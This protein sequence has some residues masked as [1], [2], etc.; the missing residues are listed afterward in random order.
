M[1]KILDIL[2]LFL[3]TVLVINLFA[4][5]SEKQATGNVIFEAT[6]NAYTIPASVGLNIKNDTQAEISLHTCNDVKV[7]YAGT[8]V[9]FNN[10]MVS[11]KDDFCEN[12]SIAPSSTYL[13]DYTNYYREF[14]QA[15]NY[16]FKVQFD[17]KEYISQFEIE[18][19][20][21]IRKL[22][23]ALFYAPIYNLLI[24]LTLLFHYSLGFGILAI[25]VFLRLLLVYP[26]HR[27]MLSQKKLQ[28]IQPKIKELQK[29]YKG[30]QQVLGMKLMELYKKEQVNPMGSLG[31]LLIQ[32]PIL[33]VIY[34]VIFHIK[35]PSNYY[36]IYSALNH[37]D[38][39]KLSY[40][41]FGMHLLDSQ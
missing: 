35:D 5:K 3:L 32:M 34:N 33:I 36:Y 12:V 10:P 8:N 4:N 41:F 18:N 25:T 21:T 22:F 14:F 16:S 24:F 6:D 2:I 30:Q 1:K 40:E 39:T 27:M 31:F 29:Q 17:E 7:N 15:G 13:L 20:G 28:A 11:V 23:T 38:L 19:P 37:F 9:E 26:Q